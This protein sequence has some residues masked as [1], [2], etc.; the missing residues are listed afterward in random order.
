DSF[1]RLVAVGMVTLIAFQALINM[2]MSTGLLPVTG[3]TLPFVSYGGSSV[4]CNFAAIAVVISVAQHR[5]YIL[6]RDPL[7]FRREQ[8]ELL[9]MGRG[10]VGTPRAASPLAAR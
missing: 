10:A 6:T 7:I 3:M 8:T 9:P 2:G 1:S 4:L 5:P